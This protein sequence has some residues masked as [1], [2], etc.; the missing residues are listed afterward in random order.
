M[1]CSAGFSSDVI[2]DFYVMEREGFF[3]ICDFIFWIYFDASLAFSWMAPLSLEMTAMRYSERVLL[4]M[5]ILST[6]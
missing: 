5:T 4:S 6:P 1:A 3:I 2:W